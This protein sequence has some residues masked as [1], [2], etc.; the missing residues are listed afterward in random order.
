MNSA[1]WRSGVLV[2]SVL[3]L[4]S[5][6]GDD[7]GDGG[8]SGGSGPRVTAS[9]TS[10]EVAGSPGDAAPVV[11]VMLN[12][13]NPPTEGLTVQG[14][15]STLGIEE[16]YFYQLSATQGELQ[17]VFK[18]PGA[19]IE[20]TYEDTID[21]QVC[22]DA[23][24]DS[25]IAGSPLTV[26]TTYEVSGDDV[27]V[28][29]DRTSLDVTLDQRNE[30]THSETIGLTLD[31]AVAGPV[32]VEFSTGM[33]AIYQ[34]SATFYSD[35]TAELYVT[36]LEGSA[37][38]QGTEEDFLTIRV[39]YEQ[40]C[41]RQLE[42]SPFTIPVKLTVGIGIEPGLDPLQVKSRTTLL[43]D[44]IDA[45]F[46][47]ALNQVV[48]VSSYP[49]N[50]LYVFDPVAGTEVQ[51]P[52]AKTPTAVSIGPDG[53]T[54]AVGHDALISVIDLQTVGQPSPPA[55]TILN[56]SVDVFDLVLDGRSRVHALPR[57]DQWESIHTVDIAT[58]VE[59]VG[60][61]SL[62][63]GARAR[64]HPQGDYLYTA[65]NGLS[66]SDIEK[67]DV[68]GDQA[69]VL[70]DSPYHGDYEMCGDLW[71]EETGVTIYTAC[72]N[73]FRSSTVQ[74]QDMTYTG[75]LD[76]SE[77][78]FYNYFIR[79]LDQSAATSEI[80]LIEYEWYGCEISSDPC[81]THLAFYESQFLNRQAVYSIGP[82]SVAGNSYAQE[83][84]FVFHDAIGDDK[85]LISKL[86]G[87]PNPLA[88]YYLSVID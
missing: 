5:C 9:D 36:F 63:A 79:H 12:V 46:S 55:P 68:T 37:L 64:L 73:T 83:G 14:E 1:F 60:T 18:V 24:C 21:L 85:Y 47:K 74:A 38:P 87:M 10:V 22:R 17:I 7:D 8:G 13:T 62:Y 23:A 49:E 3:L 88:E 52:L 56:V 43:H 28:S 45:E 65:D 27:A 15:F 67:W 70:Y 32:H 2:L 76:L 80:A 19:L 77:S 48:M 58:N 26:Q 61:G 35:T 25:E 66:P 57:E 81:Y 29:L 34:H 40:T 71:F 11:S 53:L 39:C 69:V 72:G 44:V 33:D 82:F 84:L 20:D 59:V 51:Q 16:V 6:G 86:D 54:A 31:R 30:S 41:Q 4:Q 42:G 78:D 75:A 50:A